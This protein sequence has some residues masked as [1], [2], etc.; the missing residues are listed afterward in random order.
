M[1]A[2]ITLFG[3]TFDPVHFGHL[4]TARAVAEELGCG[5]ITLLPTACP[6]HKDAARASGEDRLAMLRLAVA[7]DRLFEVCRLEL[8]RPG[9]SYTIDTVEALLAG[10]GAA[11][12]ASIIVGADMLDGLRTW[13]RAEELLGIATI[14]VACRP[15]RQQATA[16][17]AEDLARCFDAETA[18][19]MVVR[20]VQ[21]PLIDISSSQIRTRVA[22]GRPIRY[23]T[24]E[25]VATYIRQHGLYLTKSRG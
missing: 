4:I 1:T 14:V 3:G 19:R 16:T 20:T 24:P 15:G 7:G 18:A 9:P 23:L 13:R 2:A 6:P 10:G 8:D 25:P 12:R 11:G 21:T 5:L 17:A 22:E